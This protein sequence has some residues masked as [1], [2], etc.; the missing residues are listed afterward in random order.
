MPGAAVARAGGHWPHPCAQRFTGG[1]KDG[2][3][4]K[5]TRK[6]ALGGMIA[7]L[8]LAVMLAAYFPYLTYALPALAG[9]LSCS[10]LC[11]RW[12]QSG[13]FPVY[14]AVGLLSLLM[15]EKEAAVMFV[16]LFG[17]YP[18]FKGFFDRLR[19]RV[20]R[21]LV[22]QACFN[23]VAILAYWLVITVF[24]IP[25]DDMGIIG[26][27]GPIVLPAMANVCICAVRLLYDLCGDLV[28]DSYARQAAARISLREETYAAKMSFGDFLRAA[29]VIPGRLRRGGA[30]DAGWQPFVGCRLGG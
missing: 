29:R 2:N 8:S 18:V 14:V 27:Y 24:Q 30:G 4:L 25:M 7:A 21:V 19:P 13:L 26:E 12:G 28:S 20:V 1:G 22:K 9:M 17:P 10:L 16:F 3:A 6:V 5:K 11:R 15:C 23:V